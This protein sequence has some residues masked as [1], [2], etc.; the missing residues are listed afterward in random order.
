M[1]TPA[2][3]DDIR[4]Q[5]ADIVARWDD[6]PPEAV[7][8]EASA[9]QR[10]DTGP[11]H[12]TDEQPNA[13]EHATD[14]PDD[15]PDDAPASTPAPAP[16]PQPRPAQV[17]PSD[18]AWRGHSPVEDD[19]DEGYEPPPPSPLPSFW[20][21]WPFY[22]ALGGIVGGPLWLLYLTF[23][24]SRATELKWMAG[25]LIVIGFVTLVLRQPKERDIDDD[26]DG[27]RV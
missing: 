19:E 13:T 9:D 12:G 16:A 26:D 10:S 24:D 6:P 21:D 1:S 17:Q 3:D 4:A 11:Q 7:S 2:D 8:D 22:L 25:A 5:F 20:L 18:L 27:A 23:S 14:D 15:A